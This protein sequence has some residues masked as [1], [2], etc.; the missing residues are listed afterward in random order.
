TL[1]C[2]NGA[3]QVDKCMHW[4]PYNA[5]P[6]YFN[7]CSQSDVSIP[8]NWLGNQETFFGNAYL[9][10]ITYQ[11]NSKDSREIIGSNLI[12]PLQI[13]HK[14]YLSMKIS[15][16]EYSG[17]AS[18]NLG[19]SFSTIQ[20]INN[21][22]SIIYKTHCL[23][24]QQTVIKDSLNWTKLSGI[25]IADSNYQYIM[26]GNFYTDSL[27][28]V[29]QLNVN[30]FDW[31]YYYVD[32][33]CL[34]EDSLTCFNDVSVKEDK[35]KSIN[36][37]PNPFTKE[38]NIHSEYGLPKSLTLYNSTSEIFTKVIDTEDYGVDLEYLPNGIYFYVIKD[39]Y[40]LFYK[41]KLVKL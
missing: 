26:I 1:G 9:G 19:V 10:L 23:F 21:K 7:R 17:Y 28:D 36:V 5:T 34:S 37:Y 32:D 20:I 30:N 16:A 13:G 12:A 3:A 24:H 11:H 38:L 35:S 27:T 31:A 14:Y 41:G 4:K 6:D 15:L 29:E 22:N 25:F 33:I 2:P 39:D 18:N 40:G 8:E